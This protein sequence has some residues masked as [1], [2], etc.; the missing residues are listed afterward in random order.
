M[1]LTPKQKE[2]LKRPRPFLFLV[3]IGLLGLPVARLLRTGVLARQQ[4]AQMDVRANAFFAQLPTYPRNASAQQFDQLGADLG[5]V[6]NDIDSL[7]LPVNLSAE[8]DYQ[9][10]EKPLRRFL[11]AQV[12]KISGPLEALPPDLE[13]YLTAHQAG[14]IAVQSHILEREAPQ[15]EMDFERMFQ[16][17]YPFPGQINTRNVQNLLLLS[18]IDYAHKGQQTQALIALE[19]S[20]Q[21]NQAILRRPDAVSQVSGAIVSVHQAGL[22]RHLDDV[23]LVWQ[24]RLSQQAQHQSVL[25]GYRFE[26]WLQYE[27]A[28]ASLVPAI[29]RPEAA[30]A[31]SQPTGRLIALLSYWLSPAYAFR[32]SS[33]NTA[34]TMHRALDQLATLNVCATTQLMAEQIL[35]QT[36]PSQPGQTLVVVP[37]ALSRWW[38][39][40][41]DRALAIELT[42]K[43]LQAK[44]QLAATGQ[45]PDDLP[46]LASQT[47]P[48]E[49]W[50]Y[51]PSDD[52]KTITFSLST[53]LLPAPLVPLRYQST[54]GERR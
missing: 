25:E 11:H 31:R 32:L 23:P 12:N 3:V 4:K 33:I 38:K 30:G 49:H 50:V 13:D 44:Q 9:A 22:L 43:V 45:W 52:H 46:N 54:L 36:A 21:L 41:G 20:W 26:A 34:G 7:T 37:E 51:E 24:I 40:A 8:K 6:P 39:L 29:E 48:G 14:L 1:K 27:V 42:Q 10:V 18:V 17:N 16:I 15:W 53:R 2:Q 35:V 28:Q 47:C 5:F 19:A